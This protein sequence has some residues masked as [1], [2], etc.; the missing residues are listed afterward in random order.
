M[1]F[2]CA[3]GIWEFFAQFLWSVFRFCTLTRSQKSVEMLELSQLIQE[4]TNGINWNLRI[5]F[6]LWLTCPLTWPPLCRHDAQDDIV[7]FRRPPK[8]AH[9]ANVTCLGRNRLAG[10]EEQ[11]KVAEKWCYFV[12]FEKSKPQIQSEAKGVNKA[13]PKINNIWQTQCVF[14][15]LFPIALCLPTR[16][17]SAGNS[18]RTLARLIFEVQLESSLTPLTRSA[19]WARRRSSLIVWLRE[20]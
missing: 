15:L 3:Y 9:H 11:S 7:P 12:H 8:N 2:V 16:Y 5:C 19:G 20:G 10:I 13:I 14:L 4:G 6:K 1:L 18:V 17:V